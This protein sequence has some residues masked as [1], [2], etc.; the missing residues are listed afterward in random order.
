[1][2]GL[3]GRR[4][5]AAYMVVSL[6]ASACGTSVPS[7][8]SVA[9]PTVTPT[10]AAGSGPTALD[11]CDP[12]GNIACEQQAAFLSI[13]I[14]DT[15]LAL[16]WSSQWASGRTDRS[17][18][19]ANA[20][21]L[22]GWSIDAVERYMP[23]P[24]ILIG[25][26]GSW[27]FTAGVKL[28]AGSLAVPAYDGSLAYVFDVAGRHVRTVDGHLGMT[29]L[30]IAYDTAGHLA[31]VDGTS[32]GQPAHLSIQRTSDG[33]AQAIRGTDGAVTT[34]GF[35]SQGHLTSVTDPAGR[36]TSF[37]WA[38]GDLVTS[39][40][41]A[42]GGVS[43]YTYDQDGRLVA[44]SDADGVTQQLVRTATA[45]SIAVTATTALGRVTTYRTE[46]VGSGI[47][48][49]VIAPDGTTTAETIAADGSRSINEP[50]G[51]T[52]TIGA[53]ASSAWGTAAP[54]LTP[55]VTKRPDGVT[56]STQVQQALQEVGGLPYALKGTSTTTVNG[57]AW[58]TTFDP[59]GRT[60]TLVDPVGR[61]TTATYDAAGRIVA[62]SAP[63]VP[64]T[65]YAYDGTGRETSA[66]VGAGPSAQTTR[67]DLDP[68]TGQVTVT[69]PDGSKLLLSVDAQGHM[70]AETAADGSTVVGTYDSSGRLTRVQPAGGLSSTLGY[71]PAGRPTLF[72][73]PSVAGDA[74]AETTT[75][76]GDGLPTSITGLGKRSVTATYDASG[77]IASW[78]F[79]V[80][81]G[82][83]TYAPSTGLEATS[84]DPSGEALAYG[85]A[86]VQMDALHWTGPLNGSVS[87]TL[88]A[89]G[90]PTAE[91]VDGGAAMGLTY[92]GSGD[93]TGLGD[94]A[95]SRDASTGLITG[96]S[97]DVVQTQEQYDGNDQL[98]RSTT[99]VA[100]KT[101][102]DEAYT[103]DALGRVVRLVET[104]PSATTTTTY[105]YDGSD[106][107]ATVQVN[108]KTAEA[109]TYDAAG[110]RTSSK[111][112]GTTTNGAYDARGRLTAWGSTTYTWSA[113]GALASI[114]APAG[115]TTFDY[116]ALGEL[117]GVT[118]SDGRTV[119]Y[120]VDADGR[121]VGRSV[122]GALQAGYLY[123]PAGQLVAETDGSGNVLARFGYDDQ[124][125]L[126]LVERD[127]KTYR[128]ITDP[129]GSPR[130][131]IDAQTGAVA[132]AIDYDASGR[133]TRDTA[134][135]FIP[136]G[137]AGGLLDPD[138]GL[139]HL[140]VRDYD[141]VTGRWTTSDPMRFASGD[142]NLYRYAGDDAVNRD[143]PTGLGCNA[144]HVVAPILA[145][146][147]GGPL[148]GGG[149]SLGLGAFPCDPGQPPA[150]PPS[151]PSNWS[152]E[153]VEC[154]GPNGW[155]C[156]QGS[157]GGQN[158]EW[159]C[160]VG[161]WCSGPDGEG[162]YNG[163]CGGGPNGYHCEAEI[164]WGPNGQECEAE[165]G[166][167][168]NL[169]WGDTHVVTADGTHY[170][171]QAAGEFIASTSPDHAME[172]QVRQEPVL[173]GTLI[174]FNTAVAANVDGDRVG[175]Y[176]KEPSFLMVN[177]QPVTAVDLAERLPHG[178]SLERHGG[179]VTVTWPDGSRL[180]VTRDADTLDYTFAPSKAAGPGLRGLFG[181]ADG[182]AANDLTGRNG[183]ILSLTDP[184][185]H[186]KL[187]AQFGNS[188]RITPAESLFDYQP[189]ESTATFTNL[190]IP[191]AEVTVASLSA[192]TRASAQVVCQAAGVRA[193]P[194]LDD[195]ILDVGETG[196]AS[197]ASASAAVAAS[198][199]KV[200]A[201]ATSPA[202]VTPITIGQTDS[203]TIASPSQ[204]DE[205]TFTA[206]AGQIVYVQAQVTCTG[207]LGWDLLGPDGSDLAGSEVCDDLGRVVL[208]AEG[209]YTIVV[210]PD[211]SAT[212][213]YG[214]TLSAVPVTV[215]TQ[216]TLGQTVTGSISVA[217]QWADYTFQ[218][219]AGQAVYV[220]AS[221][222]CQA[223]LQ[224]DLR[225][226]DQGTILSTGVCNDLGRAVLPAAGAYTVRVYGDHTATGPFAFTLIPV[227]A[228]VV[229]AIAVG[230]PVTGALTTGG[231]W[232]DYIFQGTA[233]EVITAH[234]TGACVDGLDWQLLGPSAN[235]LDFTVACRDLAHDVLT[236]DGTY[237]IRVYGD[238]LSIGAYAFTLMTGQ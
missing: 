100:G 121:R 49:T 28:D 4:I 220:Q 118:L 237:T 5:L 209:T 154:H 92:D 48:R 97:L 182:N 205:Y 82:T 163:A 1:M 19:G 52:R 74:S 53:V 217:G 190:A 114:T 68:S 34:L 18:W 215:V 33:T 208:R 184:D 187:Y 37:S 160:A 142:T 38:P 131:V 219:S 189:G 138:T 115:R 238:R 195:C 42:L 169:D 87:V 51:T 90:R 167:S 108:G 89:N 225:G 198:G 222:T 126:A 186:T 31:K 216:V 109:D 168:C 24:G 140:G 3:H 44:S 202:Q 41:D 16:T 235:L 55:D 177:D 150:K 132:D 77:R 112:G 83:A 76:D 122:G 57:G 75:Y 62:E 170:D 233:G 192:S 85:F 32:N 128:V 6:A 141:P 196:D 106:R 223:H 98:V 54:V 136:F 84:Q 13:P 133:V 229:T 113:D 146:L 194:L 179:L 60:T 129:D 176:A 86:G 15:G 72:L 148:V 155:L 36:T 12:G 201:S 139:I 134:P 17:G 39:E 40:T 71:S 171:F 94:L 224:W 29:L 2:S 64:A 149:T 188:W 9:T 161:G 206:T 27:R 14:A 124:R 191:S 143:D 8:S 153:G 102:L 159:G 47:T 174:T 61:R 156:F 79:D 63:G 56:A 125:H 104:T 236:A 165:P 101:V 178:G 199:V 157:C 172:V 185:F 212:G 193:E 127:G 20:L 65:T 158:G 69:R 162:C 175:V 59:T 145:T 30:T 135:G 181:S 25:G 151:Q 116:D 144:V 88:D 197:F 105:T 43:R 95:L 10:A 45:T 221:A 107:L 210:N 99:T 80:G 26:D 166:G 91:S 120:L 50:D 70:T 93:L 67:Y 203:G 119:T 180:T 183:Q 231:Q 200:A 152:C 228:T 110:D 204:R 218:G 227:P 211:R 96:S 230:Q 73:P 117:R 35:D 78:T 173:G 22:G 147:V 46:A 66:T 111:A 130:L 81:T 7:P 137:F 123:D 214:F 11:E 21:G 103:R 58:T 234:A 226:P 213:A 23:T 207:P 164:C 232:A